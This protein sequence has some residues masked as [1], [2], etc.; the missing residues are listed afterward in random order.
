MD[1]INATTTENE[2]INQAAMERDTGIA[3]AELNV[4]GGASRDR[5]LMQFRRAAKPIGFSAATAST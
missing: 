3:L 2:W 1:Q 5:F 4:D